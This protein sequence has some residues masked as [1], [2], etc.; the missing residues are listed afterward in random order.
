[1]TRPTILVY[2]SGGVPVGPEPALGRLTFDRNLLTEADAVVFHVPTAFH[3]RDLPKS[4]GQVWVAWSMESDVNYPQLSNIHYMKRFDLTMTY[5]LDSD[6]PTP[7]FHGRTPIEIVRPPLPKTE[8]APLVYIASN[9]RDRSGRLAY[10]R[11]LMQHAPVDSYGK[12]L[13]TRPI[14]EDRGYETKLEIYSRYKFTLAFENSRARDYVTEKF[15]D[16]LVAGSV[17]V[18]FG[19]PNIADFAPGDRSFVDVQQF[20][21][22]RELAEYLLHVASDRSEYESYLLWKQRPLAKRFLDMV[23]RVSAPL[24][25]RLCAKL[26]ESAGS[27]P[28]GPDPLHKVAQ[29]LLQGGEP[30][31]RSTG[32]IG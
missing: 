16:P 10:V 7:Y 29:W 22:P 2:E 20:H 26:H 14:L 11:E 12:S 6:I 30:P 9:S 19:A 28:T 1:M 24:F 17:P 4:P 31:R 15:F 5:R 8:P 27:V 21:G 25:T 18:Y 23:D 32:S 3:L 13:N